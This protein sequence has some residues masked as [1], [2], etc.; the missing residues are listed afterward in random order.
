M[1]ETSF[2]IFNASAGSGKTY[3]LAKAYLKLL[4]RSSNYT[5]FKSILAIT[6]TNKAVGEM[7]ERIISTLAMFSNLKEDDS[8]PSMLID[9][10]SELSLNE[11]FI[12]S[13]SKTI[14]KHIVHNYGAF[15]ISTID[16]FNHRLIRTF[17][18]DLKLPMNFEV[19]LDQERLLNEAVD[20]LISKAGSDRAL[21]KVLVDFAIDKA[22]DDKSWDI[23]YD[24]RQIARLIVNENDIKG[25]E[26]LNFK[27]LKAFT[28]LKTK[29]ISE[30]Q[31]IEGEVRKSASDVLLALE[32]EALEFNDFNRKSL[33]NFFAKLATGQMSVTFGAQ[34]QNDLITGEAL[35]PKRVSGVVASSIDKLQ[36]FLA[37]KFSTVK[38]KL[39]YIKL[40]KSIY[41]NITPLSVLSAIKVELELVKKD[42]NLLLISEFNKLISKEIKNQPTPY[43]YERLGE[44]FKHY[45]I[46]EFQDTSK[47]Q[48]ANLVP[49]LDH[50][51]SSENS[52]TMLVGDAK[53]AIY[54][55]RGGD[56]EQFIRLFNKTVNPFQVQAEVK[57]LDTNYRSAKAIVDFNNGFFTF[58]GQNFFDNTI[59]KDLYINATQKNHIKSTGYVNLKFLDTSNTGNAD[60]GYE[61]EVLQTILNCQAKGYMLSDICII[62]RKRKEGV[63][64]S[65]YLSANGIDL[66]SSETLLLKHSG[67]V[68][69][70]NSFLKLLLDPNNSVLRIE[71][72][73]FLA[74]Q[75]SIKDRHSYYNQ[76]KN[77]DWNRCISLTIPNLELNRAKLLAIPLYE[78]V[79]FLM[80]QFELH[81][82]SDAFLQFYLDTVLE[83]VQ[84][85][86]SDITQFV[87]FFDTKQDSLSVVLPR[88]SNAVQVMTIHKSK[89]LEFPIVIFPYADLDIYRELNPQLWFPVQGELF[90][91]FDYFLVNYNSDVENY[92]ETGRQL[93]EEHQ[94]HLQLDQIN[95]LY[96][97][98]T[99]AVDQ[100]HILSKKDLSSNGEPNKK[101]FSGLFIWY[102]KNLGLWSENQNNYSFGSN[103]RTARVPKGATTETILL[104]STPKEVH[105]LNIIT[106]SGLLWN[107]EQGHAIEKGNLVHLVLSKI[108]TKADVI[109]AIELLMTS[110]EI[111]KANVTEI[112]ELIERI[113]SHPKL[114]V[115]FSNTVKTYT[116][117]DIIHP[118]G[119]LFRPDRLSIDTEGKIT[120]LD[121]K[122]GEKKVQHRE[123]L[124]E[125]QSVLEDMTYVV[126]KKLLIYINET[127]EVIEV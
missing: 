88:H 62:T 52:S 82:S 83:F 97:V 66:T 84:Q 75:H 40:L 6:F 22:N 12:I 70:L 124:Q 55:W 103:D 8:A 50:A 58:L 9:I 106:R 7:K 14:L 64:V 121:Y 24:L 71:V 30:L 61:D 60:N 73:S 89:G 74:A 21:T 48:W 120:V 90:N 125:Y 53:Q 17:A 47:L 126:K 45:F 123:Q 107:T 109:T 122:T 32:A 118:T 67:K 104:N 36:G 44:K 92:G 11:D 81:N 2:E 39:F 56:P 108:K 117:Q 68:M 86:H 100:L 49:L 95:L 85:Q 5:E 33:P 25:L 111:S 16:G 98:L 43:I 20:A 93:F 127:I 78:L 96:V 42:Q 112:T 63:K 29:L 65:E 113:I 4:F 51:L 101:T 34:W 76:H 23:S 28:G 80:R 87:S 18:H 110:G 37:Q 46:D 79:E 102:L 105:N 69:F 114:E 57:S 94:T 15:E 35:Y 27:S 119:Q 99:R 91:G 13:K 59:N 116:E 38:T 19:E 72:L 31:E 54:R 77:Q 26:S 41:R 10:C 1:S 115:Y 3:T